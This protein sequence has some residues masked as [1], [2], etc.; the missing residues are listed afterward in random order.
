[1]E[2]LDIKWRKTQFFE[3]KIIF[4]KYN[5]ALHCKHTGSPPSP[6]CLPKSHNRYGGI[7]SAP[8]VWI[9]AQHWK[10]VENMICYTHRARVCLQ[11]TQ[12][13][14]R[15]ACPFYLQPVTN[16]KRQVISFPSRTLSSLGR[17]LL[18]SSS[19]SSTFICLLLPFRHSSGSFHCI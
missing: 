18:H 17:R 6:V 8:D 11:Q 14:H 5:N 7:P 12:S 10:W 13:A 15:P 4:L 2:P 1:M 9:S 3:C 16:Q 19:L